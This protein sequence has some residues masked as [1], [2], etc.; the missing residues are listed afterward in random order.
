MDF[1]HDGGPA[2]PTT[3]ERGFTYGLDL[4]D[5]GTEMTLEP[6]VLAFA[7]AAIRPILA[8][9]PELLVKAVR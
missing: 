2:W 5:D 7:T 3:K 9:E 4:P 6:S 1:G 8:D